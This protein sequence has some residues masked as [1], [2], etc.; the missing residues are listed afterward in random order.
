MLDSG[1]LSDAFN[2]HLD[3][4][5][6]LDLS[7]LHTPSARRPLLAVLSRDQKDVRHLR[8]YEL[9]TLEKDLVDGPWQTE[10]PLDSGASS[11]IPVPLPFGGVLVLGSSSV[12]FVGPSGGAG[13]S[14]SGDVVTIA[15]PMKQTRINAYEAI[16]AG[17]RYL[18]G[19]ETG[20]LMLLKLQHDGS[21]VQALQLQPLGVCHG[22]LHHAGHFV[23]CVAVVV[24]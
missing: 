8:T 22:A 5:Y 11:L 2:V 7:F 1:N 10:R 19:D 12:S 18:L 23:V 21:T 16:V 20:R 13:P 24:C 6:V 4:L 9:H 3:D 14:N 17:D 15:T